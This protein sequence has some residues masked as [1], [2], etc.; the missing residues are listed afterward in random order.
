MKTIHGLIL[1]LTMSLTATVAFAQSSTN[2]ELTSGQTTQTVKAGELIEP[3]VFK[4]ANVDS[5]VSTLLPGLTCD[6]D[7][8]KNP[9]TCTVSGRIPANASGKTYNMK[10]DAYGTTA[11]DD[12]SAPIAITITP[13]SSPLERISGNLDQTATAGDSI[14]PIVFRYQGLRKIGFTGQ[15]KGITVNYDEDDWTISIYGAP[16]ETLQDKEYNYRLV[17]YSTDVDSVV[18]NGKITV[19]HKPAVTTLDVVENKSQNIT[20]GDSIKPIVFKFSN[21]QYREVRG[22]PEGSSVAQDDEKQ[23]ITITGLIPE[24]HSDKVYTITVIAHGLDNNDTANVTLN[25]T[26]KVAAAKV[27]LISNNASQTVKAGSAIDPLVF[28]YEHVRKIEPIDLPAGNFST[29]QDAENNTLKIIGTVSENATPGEYKVKLIGTGESNSDTAYATITVESQKA[30]VTLFQG[31]E[32]QTVSLGDSIEPLV[33]KYAFT[34]SITVTG[35]IPKGVEYS[36]DSDAHTITFFGKINGDNST[37]EYVFGLKVEGNSTTDSAKAKVIVTNKTESSSSITSSAVNQSSESRSSSSAKSSSSVKSSS[38]TEIVA[39]SSSSR[40]GKSSSSSAKNDKKSSSSN[41]TSSSSQK[42]TDIK[43]VMHDVLNFSYANNELAV[44]LETPAATHV[45]IFDMMGH[46]LE[47]HELQSSA[48]I[49]LGHLPRGTMLVRI[50][51]SGFAKTAR[52]VI[53]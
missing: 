19:N 6:C 52:I 50:S 44:S 8:P 5:V 42:T 53:K 2:F 3:I 37:K 1:F 11:G 25:I 34:Q 51:S 48:N 14:T 18:V 30:T 12:I 40:S 21:M 26:H 29:S 41:A 38:S 35:S 16:D 22:V 43:L 39:N 7:T 17:V 32:T 47:T 28:K 33:F 15:P 24:N 27:T 23:T 20:A 31:K 9:K 45:Q 46:L 36:Q 10:L 13:M 49:H 4:A